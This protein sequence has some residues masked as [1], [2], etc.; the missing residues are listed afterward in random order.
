[1]ACTSDAVADPGFLR[2]GAPRYEFAKFSQKLHE[3]KRISTPGGGG[4]S[5]VPPLDP[6]LWWTYMVKFWTRVPLLV[7]FTSFSCNFRHCTPGIEKSW[8]RRC[9]RL[10]MKSVF[11]SMLCLIVSICKNFL[12]WPIRRPQKERNSMIL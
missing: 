5:L 12:L 11:F 9:V 6:P 8:I 1:M 7:Q 3:I 10:K 2:G 4:A